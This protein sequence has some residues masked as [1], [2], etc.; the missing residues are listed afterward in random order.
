MTRLFVILILVGGVF[1]LLSLIQAQEYSELWGEAGERWSPTSRLPDF[2]FAGYH[3]GEKPIPT[4]LPT[5]N[6][7]SYGAKGD[8]EHEDSQAFLDAIAA[9]SHGTILIPAG[10]YKISQI[11]EIRHGS[12]VLRGAGPAETVLFFPIPLNK[13]KP[14]MG[15]TTSGRPTSNYSWS[16]G[17]IW[18]KGQRKNSKLSQIT[19]GSLR[20]QQKLNV[21]IPDRFHPGQ[22]IEIRMVDDVQQSLLKYHGCR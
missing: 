2:S 11:L 10:R 8:G 3:S 9:T 20:G 17:L 12:I 1:P 16:G 15:K 6:V 7:K 21:S 22:R 13:L 5:T 4:I 14:N 19:Q 18:V